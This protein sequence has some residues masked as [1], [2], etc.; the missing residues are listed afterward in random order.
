V[1]AGIQSASAA[2]QPGLQDTGGFRRVLFGFGCGFGG[3]FAF[4]KQERKRRELSNS[5]W[6]II[7]GQIKTLMTVLHTLRKRS[8]HVM[9]AFKSALDKLAQQPNLDLSKVLFNLDSS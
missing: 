2:Q 7:R 4:A 3:A 5:M 8:P 1:P 6:Y 9:E